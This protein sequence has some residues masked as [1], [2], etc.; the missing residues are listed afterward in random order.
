MAAMLRPWRQFHWRSRQTKRVMGIVGI[1]L[2]LGIVSFVIAFGDLVV[3]R[4]FR[5]GDPLEQRSVQ[6]RLTDMRQAW[7]LIRVVP[8]QGTGSGYYVGALWAGVGEDRPPGFRKVH[9]VF[10]L[11][12]A[13]LGVPGAILWLWMLLAPPLALARQGQEGAREGPGRA[14]RAG[15]A[16]AFVSAL[17]LSMLDNYLY[18]VSVW[19][20]SLYLG[21]LIGQWARSE[22]TSQLGLK[23]TGNKHE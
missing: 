22:T 8:L 23:R 3:T 7:S 11:A 16:A 15:W 2:I 4:F 13:E 20:A 9:N 18:V 14:R 19:W 12:A 21:V 1:V 10:L 17:V 5:L 6:D